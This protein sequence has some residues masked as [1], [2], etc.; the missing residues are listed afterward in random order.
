MPTIGNQPLDFFE[1]FCI[2]QQNRI[3]TGCKRVHD[4]PFIPRGDDK[5]RDETGCINPRMD[6]DLYEVETR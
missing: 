2:R 6:R 5:E 3:K 4:K 1:E